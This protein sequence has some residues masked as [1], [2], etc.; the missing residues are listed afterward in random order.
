MSP[1]MPET[2]LPIVFTAS[3]S[4]FW[5][6]P[7]MK[8]YA[9]S[10]TKSFAVAN[11]IPSVPPVMTATLPS[12]LLGIV[13]PCS[14]RVLMGVEPLPNIR[15]GI[16]IERLVKT[17]GY[18]ADMRRCQYVVQR[19][20]GV[21]RRQRLTVEYVDRRAGDLLV[22]QHA[23]QGL[24]F[25]DRPARRIDQPGR[26]LHSPQLRGPYQAARTAAQHQ[27]NRQDVR[28]LEQLVPGDQGCARCSGGL[29]RHVLAP[30]NQV[31][32]KSAPDPRDL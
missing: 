22:L 13:F 11:P 7:V 18:V 29:A 24:L 28:L 8:T 1:L 12:S 16:L 6:R 4:S 5:R 25:D 32:S 31:H 14:C 20:E 26:W 17:M 27:M 21:R 3:S 9:P 23:D 15:D 10:L 2:L 30:G 19:P